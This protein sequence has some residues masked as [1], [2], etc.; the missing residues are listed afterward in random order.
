[1]AVS[2]PTALDALI[3]ALAAVSRW[4]EAVEARPAALLWC[5]PKSEFAPLIPLLRARLLHLL[6]FG[7]YD[8][9]TRTGPAIWLRAA[10][11]GVWP[12][13]PLDPAAIPVVWLPGIAREQLRGTEGTPGPIAP[14][15]WLAVTGQFFHHRNGRDWSLRALCQGPLGL[16]IADDAA[17]RVA[18]ARA[19]PRLLL[20]PMR[21]LSRR[22]DADALDGL[23]TPDLDAD[24]LDWIDGALDPATDPERFAAFASRAKRDF[25]FDP[26]T[27]S[28]DA[29]AQRLAERSGSW[30]RVWDRFGKSLGYA[31]VVDR[32]MV[33]EPPADL[34]DSQGTY[35]KANARAASA[36]VA[37][38]ADSAVRS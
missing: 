21:D 16:D 30:A 12:T 13:L 5:D 8:I 38:S 31:G 17:T 7:T 1:M 23:L 26:A 18:L 34:F 19:A 9:K 11:A 2:E 4:N 3:E 22:W 32:L 37:A 28:R 36:S 24:L 6:T 29:A 20:R 14:L 10:V 15:A 35:P 33:R 27:Q 25:G